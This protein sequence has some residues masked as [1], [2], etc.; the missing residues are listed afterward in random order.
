MR[1]LIPLLLLCTAGC[2]HPKP[3]RVGWNEVVLGHDSCGPRARIELVL[4][5]SCVLTITSNAAAPRRASL[6]RAACDELF[7]TAAREKLEP[8]PH[9]TDPQ[10]FIAGVSVT[11]DDARTVYGCWD[12]PLA[13]RMKRVADRVAPGWERGEKMHGGCG[14]GFTDDPIQS[15]LVAPSH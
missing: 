14:F 8:R 1:R 7:A 3:T 2:V 12:D 5:R 13:T 9:C 6:E 4:H 10:P 11:L 15:E